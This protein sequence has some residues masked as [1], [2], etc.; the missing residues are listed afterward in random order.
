MVRVPTGVSELVGSMPI[1]E[2]TG[3]LGKGAALGVRL[4]GELEAFSPGGSVKD[5]AGVSMIEAAQRDGLIEPDR[6]MIVEV[7]P[8]IVLPHFRRALHLRAVLRSPDL[9]GRVVSR[10]ARQFHMP[11]LQGEPVRC[12]GRAGLRSVRREVRADRG[13]AAAG[14]R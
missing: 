6:T 11:C 13:R 9:A 2:L 10:R 5:R 12:R 3:P 1:V 14:H 8:A 4:F 7:I